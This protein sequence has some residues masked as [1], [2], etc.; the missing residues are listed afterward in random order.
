MGTMPGFMPV[1]MDDE[2]EGERATLSEQIWAARNYRAQRSIQQRDFMTA[3]RSFSPNP[4]PS[5]CGR[6]YRKMPCVRTECGLGC[7]VPQAGEH[8]DVDAPS[9]GGPS[10]RSAMVLRL[11]TKAARWNSSCIPRH[12]G[13]AAPPASW[14]KSTFPRSV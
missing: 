10:S 2:S 1:E 3:A 13:R 9:V 6:Y 11:C 7:E 12:R 4:L 14:L 5:G 8:Y